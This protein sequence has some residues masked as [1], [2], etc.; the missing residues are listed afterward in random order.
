MPIVPSAFTNCAFFLYRN[1][2]DAD[3][4]KNAGGTGFLVATTTDDGLGHHYGVTNYHVAVSGGFSCV[5]INTA[6]GTEVFEFGPEDWIFPPGGDDIAV[7]PL[8]LRQPG[9]VFL[10]IAEGLLLRPDVASEMRIGPGD[11]AF[12]VGRFIDIG[13]RERNLPA[14]RF[15]HIST[16]PVEIVQ[17]NKH[18]GLC[19]CVDMH[20]MSGMTCVIPAWRVLDLLN[21]EDLRRQR[22]EVEAARA[23]KRG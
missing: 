13:A 14:L 2:A 11:N 6:N 15:G 3:A 22:E 23:R 17:P 19:F 9:Q 1:K 7:V 21:R 4:G 16:L 18:K 12:M 5:R 8:D 20:C 10:F